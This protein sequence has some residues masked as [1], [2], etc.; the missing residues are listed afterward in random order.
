MVIRAEAIYDGGTYLLSHDNQTGLYTAEIEALQRKLRTDEKFSYY[1]IMLRVT[2][3]AGGVTV[4]TITDAEIGN[5]LLLMVREEDLFPMKFITSTSRGIEMGFIKNANSID[6]DLGDTSDFAIE[7]DADQWDSTY[8]NYGHLIYIPG[9]EYG[10]I[11]EDRATSTKLNT[12][13]WYGDTW[14]GLLDKKIIQP[15]AGQDYLSVTGEANTVIRQVLG[16]RFGSLF[17]ADEENSGIAINNYKFDR[18]VTLLSG[19]E[20]MLQT[21]GAKLRIYYKQGEGLEAGAVHLRAVPITDWSDTLEYSQDG[22]MD[23]STRDYRRGINH[24][25]CAGKGDGADRLV[26]HLYVQKDGS[27][28]DKQYYYGLNEKEALYS[29]TSADE[30]EQLREYG[31]SR[32]KEL[33]NYKQFNVDVNN[34]E[35]DIGDIVGGRDRITGMEAKLPVTGKII[36]VADGIVSIEHKIKGDE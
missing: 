35:V 2:D 3:D 31:T 16:N 5:D 20:K 34:V 28:G 26:V 4:R 17:V 33:M 12:V 13:T 15:P 9:T 29:F 18:Y 11:I 36:K 1:P 23:F 19:L 21:K 24:L 7:I 30:A 22:H 6:L 10:G 32:L 14:R 25:I 27:I 8:L